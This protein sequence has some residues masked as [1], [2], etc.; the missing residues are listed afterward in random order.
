VIAQVD[1]LELLA[2]EERLDPERLMRDLRDAG[3]E[4]VYLPDADAIAAHVVQQV[5]GGEVVI[6]FSNGGFGGLHGKLLAR[7]GRG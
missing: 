7:L 4:A 3:K 1:R 6:V 2:P 5:Q